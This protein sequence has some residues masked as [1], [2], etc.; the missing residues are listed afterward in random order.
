MAVKNRLTAFLEK[1]LIGDHPDAPMCSLDSLSPLIGESRDWLIR[2]WRAGN[3][4][5]YQWGFNPDCDLRGQ[6]IELQT[7]PDTAMSCKVTMSNQRLES[8]R[9]NAVANRPK[10]TITSA[11]SAIALTFDPGASATAGDDE[12]YLGWT[13]KP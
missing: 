9:A 10:P 2:Q 11:T 4:H 13:T 12:D 5:A 8:W 3:L 1:Q 6:K 7:H